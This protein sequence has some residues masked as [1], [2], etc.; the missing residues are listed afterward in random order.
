MSTRHAAPR[1]AAIVGA[2][3][4][5]LV[6]ALSLLRHGWSVTVHE[7]APSLGEVGA[8]LSLSRS[9]LHVIQAL[10]LFPQVRALASPVNGLPFLHYRTAALLSG[11][12]DRTDGRLDPDAD[13]TSVS[14]Q[15]HRADLHAV[16]VAAL[17]DRAP[18]SLRLG[19]R[20]D[21]FEAVDGRARLHFADGAM[22][23]ADLAI[24][25]DGV[26][27]VMR[28]R[29]WNAPPL[30]FTGQV[31]YR[32]LLD[33]ADAAPFM[34]AGR[35]AVYVGPGSVFNRYTLRGGNLVNCVSL[36]ATDDWQGEGWSHPAGIED[37]LAA[38]EGWHADVRGLLSLARPGSLIRWGLFDRAPLPRWSD[39]PFTLLGDAAHPMLPF[40]GLG[41]AMAIEDGYVLGR[42]LDGTEDL[43]AALRRYEA[44]RLPR[45]AEVA[46]LSRQQGALL[47]DQDPERFGERPSS[48]TNK[49]MYGFNPVTAPI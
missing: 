36:V 3:L 21:R 22:D 29:L 33:P 28:T 11:V 19:R 48:H 49:A 2:G 45:T 20:L 25:A 41:A 43:Q 17:R 37:A 26:R 46:S 38:H 1:S 35:A 32:C 24:G 42:A 9:T 12:H 31:A 47:Q 7:Q 44:A 5:G 34:S 6:A 39:G 10:E 13:P 14:L 16:L 15:I 18:D 40:L 8:G 23:E 30:R 27:S 4:G